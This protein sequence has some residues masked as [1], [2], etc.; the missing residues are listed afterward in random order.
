MKLKDRGADW[1]NTKKD[2]RI[3]WLNDLVGM[4]AELTFVNSAIVHFDGRNVATVNPHP[5]KK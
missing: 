5:Q 4:A 1:D 3:W 2:K